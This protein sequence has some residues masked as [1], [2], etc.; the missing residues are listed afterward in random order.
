MTFSRTTSLVVAALLWATMP[1]Y[2]QNGS[3]KV[4]S[5]PS[6]AAVVVDGVDTGK[7]TPANIALPVGDH[8]ITVAAGDGWTPDTRIVS[9]TLGN[10]ELTVTLLPALT[11]GPQGPQGLPGPQ[12]VPGP[13][14]ATGVTGATGAQGPPGPQGEPGPPGAQGIQGPK[15]DQGDPGPQGPAGIQGPKGDQGDP[16]PAGATGATGASGP[17]GPAGPPGPAGTGGP[18]PPPLQPYAGTFFLRIDGFGPVRLTSFAGCGE[19]VLGV[20]YEDCLFTTTTFSPELVQWLQDSIQGADQMR[21]NLTIYQVN[22]QSGDTIAEMDVEDAFLSEFR[23]GELDAATNDT[24]LFS[25][26]AVPSAVHM[27]GGGSGL[28]FVSSTTPLLTSRF[29]FALPGVESN[30]VTAISSLR[31]S[32]PKVVVND[33]DT[34]FSTRRQFAPGAPVADSVEMRF[35]QTA[36][37][38]IDNMNNWLGDVAEGDVQPRD[39]TLELKNQTF[40][41]TLYTFELFAVLPVQFPP[42]S[43]IGGSGSSVAQ[44]SIVFSMQSIHVQ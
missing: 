42:F 22:L 3:L 30:R 41:T 27:Q 39:G 26:L 10:N 8:S 35:A 4:S 11:A 37:N 2:A 24:L 9:I 21:R 33:P 43:T 28:P 23:L 14:G 6:G 38:T 16:G 5:F 36:T 1:A 13:P 12:G 15:G 18:P 17:Q 32:W 29:V 7:V 25:F 44:R 34:G 19:K 31:L 20:E 40:T